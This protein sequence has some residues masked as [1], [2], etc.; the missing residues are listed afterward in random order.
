MMMDVRQVLATLE[1]FDDLDERERDLLS[2]VL[3]AR[4]VLQGEDLYKQGERA[5]S[6]F[7]VAKGQLVKLKGFRAHLVETMG[8]VGPGDLVGLLSMFDRSERLHTVK[9]V[10]DSL[11]LECTRDS[12]DRLFDSQSRFSYKILDKFTETLSRNVRDANTL[13]TDLFS[14]P[15][16][17]LLMLQQAL[18]TARRHLTEF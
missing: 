2:T 13:I 6:F 4:T 7:V 3:T 8:S 16:R 9:A 5:P 18:V 10:E 14:D 17:T 11:V 15:K 1:S 12:F